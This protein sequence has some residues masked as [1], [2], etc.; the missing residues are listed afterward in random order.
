VRGTKVV[1]LTVIIV[2]LAQFAITYLPLLQGIFAT[3]PVPLVDGMLIIGVGVAL[4]AII[5]T[6]K[7]LRLRL[8][9]MRTG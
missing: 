9:A 8:Q 1:W 2:T 5:E 4:F 7:Q 6:E 3:E